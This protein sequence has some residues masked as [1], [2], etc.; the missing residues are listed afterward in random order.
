[1]A[2]E[3]ERPEAE[4]RGREEEKGVLDSLPSHRPGVESPR[5]ASARQAAAGKAT[6]VQRGGAEQQATQSELEELERLARAGVRLAGG[7]AAAGL[8]LAGRAVGGLGRV[9]GRD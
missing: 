9:V 7:A 5:R 4:R 1:V 3:A 2:H 6:A 8:R